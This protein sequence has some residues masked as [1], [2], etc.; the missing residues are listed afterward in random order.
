MFTTE[1]K[2]S[3]L[4][5]SDFTFEGAHTVKVYK[6]TTSPMNNYGRGGAAGDNWSRYGAVASLDAT[7]EDFTLARD[8][9]FTFAI[10]KLDA[11]ETGQQLAGASALSRQLRQVVVPEVDTYAIGKIVAGAGTTADPEEVTAANIYDLITAGSEAVDEAQAPDTGRVLVVS[12]KTLRLLKAS[13]DLM[14]SDGIADD[15]KRRGVVAELDGMK[16]MRI[17]SV[18]LPADF[19]FLITHPVAAVAPQKLEDYTI[20]DNPPGISGAL[21]EGRIAYDSFVLDN[22]KMAIYYQPIETEE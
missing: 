11:D 13:P 8:R 5:N 7:T 16:V 17:P 1:S 15:M 9:S 21:V 4:T 14:E 19:S 18:W 3:L 22:K 2:I 6:V 10:D 12:P 20:H